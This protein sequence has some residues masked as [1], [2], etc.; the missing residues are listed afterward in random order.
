VLTRRD[1]LIG[2]AGLAGIRLTEPVGFSVPAG[3]CDCHTHVFG[4]PARFP[5]APSRTYTPGPATVDETR[6]VHRALHIDRLVVVQPSV[7][8]TDNA[9]TLDALR[10]L[11]S[12]ARGVAVIGDDTA[13]AELDRMERAGIRGIRINLETTGQSD[14]ALARQRFEAATRRVSGR[15]WH[16]QMFTRP[17]VIAA[18]SDAVAA[19]P[20]PIVFDHFG[21]VQAAAGIDQAG[22]EALL[23]LV[24]SGKAYVKISAP[25]RGSTQPPDYPDMAPFA[26]A[27]IAANPQRILWGSDWPHP[28]TSPSA[29]LTDAGTAPRVLVADVH[30]FNL[31][32]GWAPDAALRRTILVDNPNRLYRF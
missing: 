28:N 25:Y 18:I 9:C 15:P 22:F 8:G 4:D 6:E 1:L 32:P 16:V 26:K 13:E 5:F 29:P 19:A 17:S 2:A 24:R 30:V 27:L 20:V 12:R 14:P 23:K 3:A 10:Q 31:L 21:G 11:G 7:Y